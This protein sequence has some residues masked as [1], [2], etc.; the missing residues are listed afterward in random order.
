MVSDIKR[1]P[2]ST[3]SYFCQT[4]CLTL[5]KLEQ[6]TTKIL[7]PNSNRHKRVE[8]WAKSTNFVN[9]GCHFPCATSA[10]N[11][12]SMY[13]RVPQVM[14]QFVLKIEKLSH[15]M[16]PTPLLEIARAYG[17]RP[18]LW[19]LVRH[20]KTSIGNKTYLVD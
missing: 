7:K 17:L 11:P 12:R 10:K 6:L 1:D 3:L 18:R 8:L 16:G 9:F 20:L 19:L 2:N 4:I 13:A 14:A 5:H 15:I